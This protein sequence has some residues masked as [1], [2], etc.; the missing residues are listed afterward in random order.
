MVCPK[1]VWHSDFVTSVKSGL[2]CALDSLVGV[3]RL[4]QRCAVLPALV[5]HLAHARDFHALVRVDV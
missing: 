1:M 5:E 4:G 3:C 2:V